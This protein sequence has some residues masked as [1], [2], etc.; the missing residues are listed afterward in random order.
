[1]KKTAGVRIFVQDILR[2]ISKP[3]GEDI[4]LNVFRKIE[5]DRDLKRCYTL[6]VHE[7]GKY[8]VNTWVGK[9]TKELT[10][11]KSLTSTPAPHGPII[12]SYTKLGD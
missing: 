12:T 7:L 1:M 8:A 11:M 6:L 2:K 5:K 3:Y 10:G 9:Y 4:I